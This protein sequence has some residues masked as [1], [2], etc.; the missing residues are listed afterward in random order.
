MGC[1]HNCRRD[2]AAA[3][4][5]ERRQ[6]SLHATHAGDNKRVEKGLTAS[7]WP[8]SC[9]CMLAWP[10][11]A[12]MSTCFCARPSP[13]LLYTSLYRCSLI[14]QQQVSRSPGHKSCEH[15]RSHRHSHSWITAMHAACRRGCSCDAGHAEEHWPPHD[16]LPRITCR[17]RAHAKYA[18]SCGLQDLMYSASTGSTPCIFSRTASVTAVYTS[19]NALPGGPPTLPGVL[20]SRS[21]R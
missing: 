18:A 3:V 17:R 16:K 7:R 10:R 8:K 5:S 9:S 21:C 2:T 12:H 4:D 11:K 19:S 13:G 20:S 6:E 1:G 15:G 14:R